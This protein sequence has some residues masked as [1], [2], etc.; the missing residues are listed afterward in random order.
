MRRTENQTYH[1]THTIAAKQTIPISNGHVKCYANRKK[2][3]DKSGQPN[4]LEMKTVER[5]R[6]HQIR[7]LNLVMYK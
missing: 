2:P 6:R 5:R 1:H 7:T 3:I 4:K